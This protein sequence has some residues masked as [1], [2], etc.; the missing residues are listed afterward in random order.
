MGR[1]RGGYEATAAQQQHVV[2]WRAS[3]RAAAV[4]EL[5]GGGSASREEAVA[6][7]FNSANERKCERREG[8]KKE[9]CHFQIPP[10]F[11]C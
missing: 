11:V 10:I 9:M 7:C 2:R 6:T 4:G 8:R 5:R 3:A 1:A